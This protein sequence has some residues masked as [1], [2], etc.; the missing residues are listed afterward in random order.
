MLRISYFTNITYLDYKKSTYF[1][2]INENHN[3]FLKKSWIIK[4]QSID[5]LSKGILSQSSSFIPSL[6]LRK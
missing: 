5:W 6:E 1:I 2:Y 3:Y 4:H